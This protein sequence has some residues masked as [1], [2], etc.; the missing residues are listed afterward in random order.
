[1]QKSNI[2]TAILI[3]ILLAL[4]S[5]LIATTQ[6]SALTGISINSSTNSSLHS[7]TKAIC[8]EKNYCQDYIIACK[9]Q[10]ITSMSPITGAAVQ[11]SDEWNDPRSL[12]QRMMLCN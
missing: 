12:D 3:V 10:E 9:D 7:W 6:V 1:M 4:I 2:F 5:L 8:T 11:F